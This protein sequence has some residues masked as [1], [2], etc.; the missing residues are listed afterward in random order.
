MA[1][2][3]L[4]AA[5]QAGCPGQTSFAG[6]GCV[7]GGGHIGVW[8]HAAV[9]APANHSRLRA[10]LVAGE[11]L[12]AQCGIDFAADLRLGLL[13][14]LISGR[15]CVGGVADAHV[16]AGALQL[17]QGFFSCFCCGGRGGEGG[18]REAR[19][20]AGLGVKRTWACG[21]FSWPRRHM[22]SKHTLD[23]G[24]SGVQCAVVGSMC[25]GLARHMDESSMPGVSSPHTARLTSF[26]KQSARPR[27]AHLV[28]AYEVYPANPALKT[29]A[30]A[31]LQRTAQAIGSAARWPKPPTPSRGNPRPKR[32]AHRRWPLQRR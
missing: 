26:L 16:H 17:Q 19:G 4:G 8:L 27:R 29:G 12:A 25:Q 31:W 21:R 9:Q 18:G 15:V 10:R 28:G 13:L 1:G 30:G 32:C 23:P 14:S 11:E 20:A 7:M 24:Y 6:V 22:A 3:W 5:T 2:V